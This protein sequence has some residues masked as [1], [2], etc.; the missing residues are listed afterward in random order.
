[1]YLFLI[2]DK[3]SLVSFKKINKEKKFCFALL[4]TLDKL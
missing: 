1:M 3:F 2:S 4:I